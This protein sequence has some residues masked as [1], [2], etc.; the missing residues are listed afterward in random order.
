MTVS[1]PR[2]RPGSGRVGCSTGMPS[3]S[4]V[5]FAGGAPVLRPRPRGASGRVS[6]AVIS[7]C[8]ARR[9]RTSAPKG[10]VAATAN[11]TSADDEPWAQRSERFTAGFGRRA[12]QDERSVEVVELVLDDA[13]DDP[14][15]VVP[16]LVATLVKAL[17]PHRRRALDRHR[18]ALDGKTAFVVRVRLVAATHDLGVHEDGDLVLLRREDEDAPENAD[19][20]R[21]ETDSVRVLHQLAHARHEPLEVVVELLDRRCLHAQDGVRVLADLRQRELPP[22]L[23]LGV[24]LSS[25]DLSLDLRHAG[26]LPRWNGVSAR[27]SCGRAWRAPRRRGTAGSARRS[28]R[29]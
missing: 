1:A 19:L 14:F 28:R 24:Q 27:R 29:I 7:W 10:A 15:E 2:S 21:R 13:R 22:S 5:S 6:S 25:S 11:S 20:R 12:V 18:D 16:D 4:A 23:V 9:S 26:T 3:R 17:D 8:A